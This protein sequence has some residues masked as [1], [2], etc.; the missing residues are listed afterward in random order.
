MLPDLPV[1]EAI[2]DELKHLDLPRRGILTDLAGRRRRERDH[3]TVATRAPSCSGRFE[4]A[5]VVAVSTQDLLALGG[6]H[7]PG[8]GRSRPVL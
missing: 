3:G 7:A 6:V 2:S 1:D 4:A 8:I 5:A